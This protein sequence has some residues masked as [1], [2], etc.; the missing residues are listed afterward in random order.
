[1]CLPTSRPENALAPDAAGSFGSPGKSPPTLGR[2]DWATRAGE[3]GGGK[4]R[5]RER[6]GKR[7]LKAYRVIF[8]K[9]N[10]QSNVSSSKIKLKENERKSNYFIHTKDTPSKQ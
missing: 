6:V 10:K 7:D 9:T 8:P 5:E 2:E 3:G 4:G 1:M